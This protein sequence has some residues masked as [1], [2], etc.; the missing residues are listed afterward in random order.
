MPRSQRLRAVAIGD[1]FIPAADYRRALDERDPSLITLAE[2]TWAGEKSEQHAVQQI[3]ERSGPNSVPAPDSIL[4]A[5]AGAQAAML[6]FAPAGR[7]F[8][9]AAPELKLIAVARSGL[10]NVDVESATA[11]GICVVPAHGRNAG[12][13]A[14]LQIA[15]MLAETR[16]VAR[17]DASIKHGG[18]RKEFPGARVEIHGRTVGMVGFGHVGRV[19][20]QRL[21]GF[22]PNLIAYDPYATDEAMAASGVRRAGTLNEVFEQSDFITVQAKLTP[23]TSRFIGAEQF[24][25][26]KPTAYFIN[27]SRSRLVDTEA[28]VAALKSETMS[29][30]GVDVFDEEPL[31]ADHPLRTLDNVTL[32]THFGGDTVDT[33]RVSSA[34]CVDAV[35]EFAATGRVGR[36]V[37]ADQLGWK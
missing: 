32:T 4:P 34:L 33:N 36:A 15:L 5:L 23:E 12:A 18:W 17:A 3:M 6:H 25:R 29:G 8:L 10:E 24:D 9:A 26:M 21:A 2:T 27:V 13:V 35:L 30:A 28:L 31:P 37:N 22:E 1:Q 14:E 20:A 16:N 11:R 7:A 19:F